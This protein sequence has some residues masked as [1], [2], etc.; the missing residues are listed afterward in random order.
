MT[1]GRVF[2]YVSK[3]NYMTYS[4]FKTQK[5]TE[6]I[7]LNRA[8][9]SEMLYFTRKLQRKFYFNDDESKIFLGLS[10]QEFTF[11]YDK[12]LRNHEWRFRKFDGK[13]I[14]AC[15]MLMIRS[16]QPQNFVHAFLQK[17]TNTNI[18]MQALRK[19]FKIFILISKFKR[20]FIV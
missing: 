10:G 18:T 13:E 15:L 9:T 2:N 3:T 1:L 6:F 14:F 5:R 17:Y 4:N 7:N 8:Y 19:S 20:F 16:G 11:I 12:Y